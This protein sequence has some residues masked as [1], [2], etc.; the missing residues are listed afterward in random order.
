MT[1]NPRQGAKRQADSSLR[2]ITSHHPRAACLTVPSLL[3]HEASGVRD[4]E[5][6][7]SAKM[8]ERLLEVATAFSPIV[9]DGRAVAAETESGLGTVRLD[10]RGLGKLHA[11]PRGLLEAVLKAADAAGLPGA[12]AALTDLPFTAAVLGRALATAAIGARGRRPPDRWWLSSPGADR[13]S[14]SR[15]PLDLL[16]APET[17]GLSSESIE[18]LHLLAVRTAGAFGALPA[19]TIER[20]FGM[21]GLRLH[22]LARAEVPRPLVPWRSPHVF[23]Q[24]A[25]LERTADD[26]PS[27]EIVLKNLLS[28]LFSNLVRERKG[29]TRLLAIYTLESSVEVQRE[30]EIL[31]PMNGPKE[32]LGLLRLDLESRPLRGPVSRIMLRALHAEERERRSGD[33]LHAGDGLLLPSSPR[34]RPTRDEEAA[35]S[36]SQ[37]ASRLRARLGGGGVGVPVLDD[38]H[39]PEA[40][41]HIE[42]TLPGR[43]GRGGSCE[44]RGHVPSRRHGPGRSPGS[45]LPLQRGYN[46]SSCFRNVPFCLTWPVGW[47]KGPGAFFSR[48]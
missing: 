12:V 28:D 9:E 27:L 48:S 35:V 31:D 33:L 32:W 43:F 26:L 38:R 30:I 11:T 20:R 41:F 21:E 2:A 36:L 34:G 5:T 7:Q 6:D 13:W 19:S 16:R 42:P 24:A 46:G 39:R 29:P 3:L 1:S 8:H 25:D 47:M 44:R 22:R 45:V 40:A 10:A 4:L 23:E 37:A 15:L 14:L 18:K 17:P